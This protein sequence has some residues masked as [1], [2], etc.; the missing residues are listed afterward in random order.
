MWVSAGVNV[1]PERAA[2]AVGMDEKT[3][4]EVLETLLNGAIALLDELERPLPCAR[5]G[6]HVAVGLR[7]PFARGTPSGGVG[8]VW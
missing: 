2:A 5:D 1:L 7:R 3:L 6:R 4:R 8:P